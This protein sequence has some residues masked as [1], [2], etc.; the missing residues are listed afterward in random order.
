M[1]S[2]GFT[3]IYFSPQIK[4]EQGRLI[5]GHGDVHLFSSP[6]HISATFCA[7]AGKTEMV[8]ITSMLVLSVA[9]EMASL[10]PGYAKRNSAVV[11]LG[12]M[13]LP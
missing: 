13:Q 10:W 12:S 1:F 6:P 4:H 5:Q 9:A 2:D 11:C 8:M 7:A 3:L